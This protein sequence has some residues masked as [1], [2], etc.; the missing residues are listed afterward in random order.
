LSLFFQINNRKKLRSS[1]DLGRLSLSAFSLIILLHSP[2]A[3]ANVQRLEPLLVELLKTHRKIKGAMVD[4]DAEKD[5]LKMEKGNY[6][7]VLDVTVNKGFENIDGEGISSDT[8]YNFHE[9]DL[10]LTQTIWDFGATNSDV[11]RAEQELSGKG[12][13]LEQQRQEALIE[14]I[15]AFLKL[16]RA[17]IVL[18]FAKKSEFNTRRRT[19]LEEVLLEEGAGL[20]ADVIKAKKQLATAQTKWFKAELKMV[21]QTNNFKKVFETTPID[22][23]TFEEV[24]FSVLSHIPLTLHEVVERTIKNNADIKLAMVDIDN[25]HEDVVA[26]RSRS[27]FPTIEGV[28]EQKWKNN[29]GGTAGAKT[30]LLGMVELN[31]PF[32]LGMTEY[33]E[34]RASIKDKDSTTIDME[35]LR[36]ETVEEVRN[37]WQKLITATLTWKTLKRQAELAAASLELVYK[38]RELGTRSQIDVLTSETTL[39]NAQSKARSK[40]IDILIHAFSLLNLMGDVNIGALS[41]KILPKTPLLPSVLPLFHQNLSA[42]PSKRVLKNLQKIA[43]NAQSKMPASFFPPVDVVK[44]LPEKSKKPDASKK[45]VP[46]V[47]KPLE[48]SPN[49]EKKWDNSLPPTQKTPVTPVPT[50]LNRPVE[51]PVEPVDMN[52]I[53]EFNPM[54]IIPDEEEN[55]QIEVP[56]GEVDP[57]SI[58][59]DEEDQPEQKELEEDLNPEEVIPDETPSGSLSPGVDRQMADFRAGDYED[60]VVAF[61]GL[62]GGKKSRVAPRIPPK[63]RM[64]S[65][66]KPQSMLSLIEKSLSP[67]YEF[68]QEPGY[69]DEQESLP[70]EGAEMP[71]LLFEELTKEQHTPHKPPS[72][73]TLVPLAPFAKPHGG[74]KT[75]SRQLKPGRF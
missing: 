26:L 59:P 41:K 16:K 39:L 47:T 64:S 68:V 20:T 46:K 37:G 51:G 42:K 53:E 9:L 18:D 67:S 72:I 12:L 24:D 11:R 60:P 15:T 28:L 34:Y 70:P 1:S 57:A 52:L 66:V 29:V 73:R 13:L 71:N 22:V 4:L 36:D 2:L 21:T 23:D 56:D 5:R 54:D 61:A 58:I 8:N 14:G 19:G 6:F 44:P 32:S 50:K 75:V 48:P 25:A 74:V 27:F 17:F 10:T 3:Q 38:E 43:N 40:R 55:R 30:E 33:N 31:I 49:K 7:P 62:R 35:V 69:P 65:P 45:S 63:Q